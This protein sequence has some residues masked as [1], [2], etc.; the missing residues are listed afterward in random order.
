MTGNGRIISIIVP[1]FNVAEF[2]EQ[3]VSGILDQT[4]SDFELLLVDDGSTD[5]SGEI[6]DRYKLVDERIRVYHKKNGGLSDARNFGIS[7]AGGEYLTFIDPDDFVAPEYLETLYGLILQY[8]SDA[9]CLSLLETSKR[10]IRKYPVSEVTGVL[11]GKQAVA[12]SLVRRHFGVSACGKL[13]LRRLFEDICF[14]AGEYFEDLLTIPYVLER[15]RNVAYSESKLYYY[16]Q[17]PGSITNSRITDRHLRFF[18]NVIRTLRYFDH[19]GKDMHDAFAA[20][21]TGE[22]INRFAEIL[23]FYPDYKEKI[24]Y[25]KQKM[26][27]YWKEAPSNPLIP[28]TTIFQVLIL[29]KSST[30]YRVLFTPYKYVKNRIK[31]IRF[32]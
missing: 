30:L 20:R 17:R 18:D 2:L 4:F 24:S 16:Y 10:R 13:F 21:I 7:K 32:K 15:C 3:C 14:P 8:G 22:S 23:L 25:I 29:N 26:K 19:Y 28:G 12:D 31:G 5:R 6:C 27:P 11:S 1:V 9:A